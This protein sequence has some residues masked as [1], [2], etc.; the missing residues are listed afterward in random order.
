MCVHGLNWWRPTMCEERE[1]RG[2]ERREGEGGATSQMQRL[3]A[4]VCLAAPACFSVTCAPAARPP[5]VS[6][7]SPLPTLLPLDDRRCAWVQGL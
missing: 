3:I 7:S 5:P 2:R 4:A 1:G 6:S